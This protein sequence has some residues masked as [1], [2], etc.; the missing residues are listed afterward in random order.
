MISRRY[1]HF[2]TP[3]FPSI[4]GFGAHGAIIHYRPTLDQ[5]AVITKQHMLLIDSGGQYL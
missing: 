1:A 2:V 5:C 3:S 4:V